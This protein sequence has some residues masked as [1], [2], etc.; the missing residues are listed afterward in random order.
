MKPCS[1]KES[2][3]ILQKPMDMTD[4]ECQSLPIFSNEDLCVSKRKMNWPERLH[5]LFSGFV[6]VFVRSKN[7]QPAIAVMAY[8]SAF[9]INHE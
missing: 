8:K 6:W 4:K 7:T 3:K 5:C 9:E 1:F 2:N